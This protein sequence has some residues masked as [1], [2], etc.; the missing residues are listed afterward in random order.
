MDTIL[1]LLWFSSVYIDF[2]R[3]IKDL[4]ERDLRSEDGGRDRNVL[5][6]LELSV[7]RPKLRALHTNLSRQH[8][9]LNPGHPSFFAGLANKSFFTKESYEQQAIARS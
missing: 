5:R 4:N 2:L 3:E 7:L 9:L 6:T 1:V 8:V